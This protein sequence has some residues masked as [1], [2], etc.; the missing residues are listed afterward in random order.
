MA[1]EQVQRSLLSIEERAAIDATETHEDGTLVQHVY[2]PDIKEFHEERQRIDS[3]Y[4]PASA[5]YEERLAERRERDGEA[6]KVSGEDQ[7]SKRR[8]RR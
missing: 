3:D 1:E 6:A 2:H 7:K 8:G 5:E 4:V